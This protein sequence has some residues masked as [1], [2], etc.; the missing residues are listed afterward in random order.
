MQNGTPAMLTVGGSAPGRLAMKHTHVHTFY[1]SGGCY[2]SP[3]LLYRSGSY[4]VIF[5]VNLP[6]FGPDATNSRLDVHVDTGSCYRLVDAVGGS[7]CHI[8]TEAVPFC[9]TSV[10]QLT[11]VFF[12]LTLFA[13]VLDYIKG[14]GHIQ[15]RPSCLCSR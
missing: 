11:K 6:A 7:P 9:P 1:S 4:G 8:S 12:L 5:G 13:P 2:P 14:V 10:R 3:R 15:R